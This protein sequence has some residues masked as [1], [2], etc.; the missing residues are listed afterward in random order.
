VVAV[1]AGWLF[2]NLMVHHFLGE[3]G[4]VLSPRGFEPQRTSSFRKMVKAH[5]V[6]GEAVRARTRIPL[7][8]L[9][10]KLVVLLIAF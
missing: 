9:L 6:L 4:P 5:K 7:F 1:S 2:W 8:V 3:G 10:F